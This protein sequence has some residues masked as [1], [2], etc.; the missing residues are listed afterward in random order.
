[1]RV[2]WIHSFPD[3]QLASGV[4]MHILADSLQRKG[5]RVDLIRVMKECRSWR[6][7]CPSREFKRRVARYDLLHAQYGSGCATLVSR[8]PGTKIV[9]LRGSDWYGWDSPTLKGRL[10][11]LL[12]RK[13]TRA[14]LGRFD[15]V[16]AVSDRMRT[17]IREEVSKIRCE[18][19]PSGVDLTRFR[20]MD[21]LE[22]RRLLGAPNDSSPWVLFSSVL[23]YNPLK[24]QWL[25]QAAVDELRKLMPDVRFQTLHGQPHC[26]VPT[27]INTCDALILTSTHEGW[28]NIVKESLACN[29]P[30]VST[31]VS[32]LA[33]ITRIEPA[34]RVTDADP[35]ALA[36]CLADVLSRPRPTDLRRHVAHMDLPLVAAKLVRLYQEV[37]DARGPHDERAA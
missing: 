2:A 6:I 31:D 30:F 11:W 28:P 1:M 37:L 17:E 9:T 20:P 34:C 25:A 26:E 23:G 29:V 3:D 5:I 7:A 32:D 18:T 22:A 36:H 19:L 35:K 10:H 12:S 27:F 13:L 24:R 15:L 14:C 16:I 21:R 4:F 33:D 8:L